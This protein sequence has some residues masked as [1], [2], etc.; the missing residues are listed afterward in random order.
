MQRTF[1]P[2]LAHLLHPFGPNSN[3]Q[4]HLLECFS[5]WHH[6]STIEPTSLERGALRDKALL[7]VSWG[8]ASPFGSLSHQVKPILVSFLFMSILGFSPQLDGDLPQ[9]YSNL[10]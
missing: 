1:V 5:L 2:Y 9:K 6:P 10:F 3:T 4:K 7:R 8:M